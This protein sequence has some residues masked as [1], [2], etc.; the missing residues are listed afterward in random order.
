MINH[1][2]LPKIEDRQRNEKKKEKA[3]ERANY[4]ARPESNKPAVPRC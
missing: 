1:R 4:T 3:E 2:V